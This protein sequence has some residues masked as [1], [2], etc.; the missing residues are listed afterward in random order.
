MDEK[1][2][3]KAPE[4]HELVSEQRPRPQQ[5]QQ[6]E[7][8]SQEMWAKKMFRDRATPEFKAKHPHI[9]TRPPR[10]RFPILVDPEYEA[11]W[12]YHKQFEYPGELRDWKSVQK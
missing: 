10:R 11:P 9:V 8:W 6:E 12:I 3:E 1:D 7:P 2:V 5:Q 4:R